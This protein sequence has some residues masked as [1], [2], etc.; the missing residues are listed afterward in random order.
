MNNSKEMSF[1]T[2]KKFEPQIGQ[3]S[4]K[5]MRI[6]AGKEV[7]IIKSSEIQKWIEPYIRTY[8]G[9]QDL[10]ISSAK[11]AEYLESI[12]SQFNTKPTNARLIFKDNR[13]E[14]FIPHTTGKNLDID[15]S[16]SLINST[17]IHGGSSVSLAFEETAPDI[18]LD[19]INNLGIKT[20]LGRGESDYGKSS[21]ARIS[22]IKVG[23][24]KFNGAILKPG[25]EFSFNKL[26][27]EVDEQNGYQAELVIKSGQLV[28]EFGGGLCQVA[29]TVFRSAIMTGLPIVER[30]PHSFPVH[31]YDPQGFDATIYPGVVDL[32]FTNNTGN[33]ILIQARLA[34]SRLSVEIYGSDDGRK[35]TMD[36]PV[37]YDQ[38]A[39]GAMKAYFTRTISY[40]DRPELKERFSSVYNPPPPSPLERNPLE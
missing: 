12:A 16:A 29:T 33:H 10:R 19:T 24:T 6:Q 3:A 31:Y 4:Q 5:D 35:V 23:L 14:V 26:L 22:N 13:A 17:I 11:V 39:N 20:L 38:K 8:S 27:G 34:G 30:K 40:L 15:M 36:G 32:R 1:V 28:K 37:H 25:E 9:E 7:L 21:A 2:L 18:T